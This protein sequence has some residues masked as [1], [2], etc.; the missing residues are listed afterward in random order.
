MTIFTTLQLSAPWALKMSYLP[1]GLLKEFMQR[2][3]HVQVHEPVGR[4]RGL[5]TLHAP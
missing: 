1:F 2:F 3:M 5:M 4:F